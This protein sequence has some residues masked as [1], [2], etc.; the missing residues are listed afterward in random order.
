MT[1]GGA[2]KVVSRKLGKG[3]DSLL[4]TRHAEDNVAA[5]EPQWVPVEDLI[6]NREQPRKDVEVGIERLAE[7][8]RRHGIMQ[9]IVVTQSSPGN[10]EI[11]AGERRWRAAQ[12]A[13]LKKVP[14]VLKEG[15]KDLS[16]RLELAL[17][18][19]VQREDLNPIDRAVACKRLMEE[20]SLTQEAVAERLGYERSTLA[21]LVRLLDLPDQIQDA[22][23]RETITAGHARALLRLNESEAQGEVFQRL[24]SEAWSVRATEKA[25]QEALSA[26]PKSD[27]LKAR[28]RQPAWVSD[29]QERVTRS[30]GARSEIKLFRGGKGRLI[31]HFDDL[32]QLDHITR[33]LGL[34]DEAE[35][36]LDA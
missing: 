32:D 5:G 9:P 26:S 3:L 25:C 27:K 23:S 29:L 33:F 17:I 20:Y 4:A 35:D 19:N 28:P 14:V 11:L 12:L 16:E 31:L 34:R 15:V 7:S 22:V 30:L 8:V 2:K 21:N 36:L 24:L 18:E 13:G 1:P 10:F 6:P